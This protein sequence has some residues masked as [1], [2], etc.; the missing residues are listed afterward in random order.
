MHFVRTPTYADYY[1]TGEGGWQV[2]T[3]KP[4]KPMGAVWMRFFVDSSGEIGTELTAAI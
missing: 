3:G 2:E 1:G 4:P